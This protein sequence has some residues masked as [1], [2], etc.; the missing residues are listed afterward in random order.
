MRN[1]FFTIILTSLILA[2]IGINLVHVYFFKSQRLNLIDRQIN[3]SA[4]MLL[5]S[6]EFKAAITSPAITEKAITNVLQGSRIG[7][8]FVVKNLDNQIIYESFN[9]G[10]LNAD[11]PIK[12]EWVT[13]ETADE[14][15]RIKNV[16]IKGQQTVILQ[17]GL[18]LNQNFLNW[19]I[20]DARVVRYVSFIV[21]ALFVAAVFLT[22]TLLAPLRHLNAHLN[23]ATSNLMNMKNVQE[24]PKDLLRYT[25]GSW[26]KADE[27]SNLLS[28]VQKLIDRIN[29]NYKLTRSWTSQMAHELKTPLAIIKLEAEAISKG[30]L[31]RDQNAK[32]ILEEVRLMTDIIS[33]F[34]DW[35]EL[36]ST[37]GQKDL[38]A[39]RINSI[40]KN[41]GLRLEKMSPNRIQLK[42]QSDFSVIANPVH[43]DQLVANLM[44][45][46]LKFS[47]P[48]KQVEVTVG[49]ANGESFVTVKDYGEG[50]PKEVQERF[51]Q[52]FNVGTSKEKSM[53]GNGLG[54]AWVATV[55]KLY[56]WKLDIKT[57]SS[58]TAITV[59]FPKEEISEEIG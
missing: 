24:L 48:E 10:L 56:Q 44:T 47:A 50:L 31:Q 30:S 42:L 4:E 49:L 15:V 37:H 1:R 21:L 14:Y 6:A 40:I 27:F 33:Q 35:A 26:S 29:S 36:E 8:V 3:E 32:D 38:H 45:N 9:V 55:A 58:G 16:M 51:G 28:T 43:V 11:L 18:V 23:E 34:L 22:L 52:P 7:K 20:V 17:V 25:D 59:Y 57:D 19:E 41:V 39:V 5:S 2:A 12:P 54:L 46:A 53:I 13:V